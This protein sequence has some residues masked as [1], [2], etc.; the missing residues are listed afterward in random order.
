MG[1]LH[2]AGRALQARFGIA[3]LAALAL[4][5]G[6]ASVDAADEPEKPG[7]PSIGEAKDAQVI[8]QEKYACFNGAAPGSLVVLTG[9][10]GGPLGCY[11]SPERLGGSSHELCVPISRDLDACPDCRDLAENLECRFIVARRPPR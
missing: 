6:C 11:I 9:E 10:P 7:A 1:T 8:S 3:L 4:V 2:R 5:S